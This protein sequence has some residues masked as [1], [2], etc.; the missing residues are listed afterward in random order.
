MFRNLTGA[1]L[2]AALLTVGCGG[3]DD[4]ASMA[5]EP[6][7]AGAALGEVAAAMG[8][9]GLTS[10][11]YS[12]TG[13]EV[14][15]ASFLQTPSASPPWPGYDIMNYRRTID[16]GQPAS[17]ATGEM[18][19][20]G[21]FL[22]EPTARPYTQQIG[23]Q[24]T[25]WAQQLEIWLTPWGFL[26]GAE[27][28]GAE[29][30][31]QMVDG[32]HYDVISWMSP[33]G[34]IAPSGM[35][36]T[37]TGYVNDQ[38]LI[39][40]VETHV[41]DPM[42]GDMLV[43]ATYGDY[44]DM[45]GLMVPTRMAQVRGGG[46]VFRVTVTEAAG[47]PANVAELVAPPPPPAG[48][49]GGR[50]GRAGGAG[51]G[52]GR[53]AAEAPTDLVTEV[54]EGV[55]TVR[56]AYVPLVVEFADHLAVFEAGV[57]EALG[58]QII[59]EVT[60]AFP[61]KPIRYIIN[62][63]P[64][65][66]HSSGIAPFLRAGATLITQSNNVEALR[67]YFGN[68]RTLLGQPTMTP[69]VEGVDQM[70]VLEDETNRLELYSVPNGHTDGMLVAFVPGARLLHQAD[71]TLPQPGAEPNPFVLALAK[72][73]ADLDLDFETYSGVHASAQ[74]QTKAD[75]MATIGM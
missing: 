33:E 46:E 56:V 55:Y 39:E 21:L 24:Q 36:Y 40:R 11:T 42:L 60:R 6:I 45:G 64:H 52:G 66:D 71:F 59:D 18:F 61:D 58:Q 63:H 37:V 74:P 57:N 26:R 1:A 25:N 23:A 27:A 5:P 9:E 19:H 73:M 29:G 54:S 51:R 75:L 69:T 15:N 35:R 2:C 53:G 31:S 65:S 43:Q 20:G 62:S 3:G 48:R 7:D 22:E 28:N 10:I 32:V 68:P 8:A 4:A 47:N 44:Q 13:W 17:R 41:E 16:L 50:G 49:G 14:V 30:T 72:R 34:Q 67:A 38:H 12:G 70:R